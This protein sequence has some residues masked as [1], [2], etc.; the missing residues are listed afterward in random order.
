MGHH[1]FGLPEHRR[2]NRR[3]RDGY[4]D[5]DAARYYDDRYDD[6]APVRIPRIPDAF[7]LIG[8]VVWSLLTRGVRA[9]IVRCW[10]LLCAWQGRLYCADRSPDQSEAQ[11]EVVSAAFQPGDK[12]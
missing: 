9:Q 8:F 5:D 1:L 12:T 6:R 3:R 10:P 2:R 11:S 7:V 4:C